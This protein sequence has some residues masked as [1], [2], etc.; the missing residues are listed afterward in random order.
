MSA[1]GSQLSSRQLGP[2]SS[3]SVDS[4]SAPTSSHTSVSSVSAASVPL[5]TFR[6]LSIEHNTHVHSVS[7]YGSWRSQLLLSRY[8]IRSRDA[9][10]DVRQNTHSPSTASG[11]V[12]KVA[13]PRLW[14]SARTAPIT[15]DTM[16]PNHNNDNKDGEKD[17]EIYNEK[18]KFIEEES[19]MPS[20]FERSEVLFQWLVLLKEFIKHN[21]FSFFGP[22]AL[23]FIIGMDG[24]QQAINQGFLPYM[25]G[26][27]FGI[28]IFLWATFA[29]PVILWLY[30][31]P[32]AISPFEVLLYT[33]IVLIR[34]LIIGIKY[35]FVPVAEL[36]RRKRR[37]LNYLTFGYELIVFGWSKIPE[38]VL[39][40]EL[41]ATFFRLDVN[42][43][44]QVFEFDVT[45]YKSMPMA[46]QTILQDHSKHQEQQKHEYSKQ[47]TVSRLS[48]QHDPLHDHRAVKCIRVPAA[49]VIRH[50]WTDAT[51]HDFDPGKLARILAVAQWTLPCFA[52]LLQGHGF[53]GDSA[54]DVVTVLG[55]LAFSIIG[56]GS[57]LSFVHVGFFDFRRRLFMMRQCSALWSAA[58]KHYQ[59]PRTQ[60]LPLLYL[61]DKSINAWHICRQTVLDLGRRYA[62]RVQAYMSVF[63]AVE[64]LATSWLLYQLI[65]A[66]TIDF[67]S[68]LVA[69]FNIIVLSGLFL[70]LIIYGT[71]AN[72]NSE[73]HRD[74]LNFY[75]L[76]IRSHKA[77]NRLKPFKQLE[78]KD[79]TEQ[80]GPF[81]HEETV[82]SS[83]DSLL[84]AVREEIKMAD[85][86]RPLSVLGFRANQNLI[87]S[88][89]ALLL[90]TVAAAVSNLATKTSI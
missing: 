10:D 38:K 34:N 60:S 75:T 52:R 2:S 28:Q 90:S 48:L 24:M 27:V 44:N 66:S 63:L 5:N 87:R 20:I 49:D 57:L 89:A 51:S 55:F 30:Y 37:L 41:D 65:A 32:D 16:K 4:S 86:L 64:L 69:S 82:L 29:F 72:R 21:L 35:G 15:G 22:F 74:I 59:N 61:S 25:S 80:V 79:N 42:I 88:L 73:V 11:S 62:L 13:P 36:E 71:L 39:E 1:A 54:T 19:T 26:F 6:H 50:L 43:S 18:L 67:T 8:A 45:P 85:K 12:I 77:E 84:E 58:F 40:E 56:Y 7:T 23:P 78:G 17:S 68:L 33:C 70:P 3:H 81:E 46:L 47:D 31:R 83:C 14:A 76:R 9:V 53:L